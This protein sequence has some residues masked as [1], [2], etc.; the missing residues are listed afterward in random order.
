M[1]LKYGQMA[2]NIKAR[3]KITY[4]LAK[5]LIVMPMETAMWEPLKPTVSTGRVPT[6]IAMVVLMSGIGSL[7]NKMGKASIPRKMATNT[8]A[9][10][11]TIKNMAKA[12]TRISTVTN[13]LVST[14]IIKNT[15]KARLLLRKAPPT[16]DLSKMGCSTVRVHIPMP[17]ATNMWGYFQKA[18]KAEKEL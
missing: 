11:W 17:M 8:S 3:S 9:L 2:I 16:L 15:V 4:E 7:I 1:A 6:H 18:K 12:P 14:R 13:T 5:G 10:F